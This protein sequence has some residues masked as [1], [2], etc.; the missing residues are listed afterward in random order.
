MLSANV[1]HR[2]IDQLLKTPDDEESLEAL[3]RLLTTIGK[4]LEAGQ[5]V[6]Q[7]IMSGYFSKLDSI[8]KKRKVANRIRFMIQDLFDLRGNKW[9][10]RREAGDPRTIDQIHREVMKEREKQE[11]ELN[12]VQREERVALRMSDVGNRKGSREWSKINSPRE[13]IGKNDIK[14]AKI[15]K[16]TK[17]FA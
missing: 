8:V 13:Q 15:P 7:A 16:V 14:Q 10:P 11:R 4:Q 5:S 12:S 2:C 3:C 1:M 6:Q 9:A 17:F